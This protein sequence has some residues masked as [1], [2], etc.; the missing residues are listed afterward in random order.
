[1]NPSLSDKRS[2]T[3]YR[4]DIDG[5]RSLAVLAVISFHLRF[6]LSGGFVG[7][8]IFFVI[9]GYL[10]T[11]IIEAGIDAGSFSVLEF[12]ARRAR[13]IL[14]ALLSTVFAS[15]VVASIVL[16][17]PEL[18]AF[19]KSALAAVLFVAN[20][21]FLAVSG[22]FAPAANA[23]PLLHLWSLGIEEQFYI[24]FPVI[25]L[26]LAKYP[27]KFLLLL[28]A[29][30]CIISLAASQ[31]LAGED[32]TSA[33]YLL[34]Y[35]GFELLIGCLTALLTAPRLFKNAA[36]TEATSLA[37]AA[38]LI[39]PAVF[40]GPTTSYPGFGAACPAFGAAMVISAG[41]ARMPL[42]SKWLSA[43]PLVGIGK[44][45][46]SLY[47]VHWPV[48]V[49]GLRIFPNASPIAFAL[50]AVAV[51]FGLALLNY[52][53][54]EQPF[55]QSQRLRSSKRVL[56]TAAAA[57]ACLCG[58]SAWTIHEAGFSPATD[59]RIKRV[60]SYLQYDHDRLY[61]DR[62]CYLSPDQDFSLANMSGCLPQGSGIPAIL[63]GDSH[64]IHLY[65]GLRPYF[66]REGFSLGVL[67]AS[68]C[69]PIIDYHTPVRPKCPSF[70]DG[71]LQAIL[72]LRPR[73][74]VLSARWPTDDASV[75]LLDRTVAALARAGIKVVILGE[76]PLYRIDVPLII[77][78]RL[79]ARDES[80]VANGEFDLEIGFLQWSDR[81]L[82][83]RFSN[84]DDVKFISV[85]QALCPK[86]D[87]PLTDA[88]GAP[89]HF[90]TAH[91]TKEGSLLF[92]E[93]LAP[94][95]LR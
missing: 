6:G 52:R 54:V 85:M 84:R 2:P 91:L 8:D 36:A 3:G 71:A 29:T 78:K 73:I 56:S 31:L 22:Y 37:G 48:I 18:I 30:L 64:A 65:P 44:I 35:R 38:L 24:L 63:W 75:A 28:L 33:F 13:R 46:Y 49:F 26:V 82:S 77:A 47:L 27:R 76:S 86:N 92:A 74:V 5:L 15:S 69:A 12:Y 9:S 81:I 34:P 1:M 43:R 17:P 51:S 62:E 90:D 7:V 16:Y 21:H 59:E 40:F 45:S 42:V 68:A 66:E 11:R 14:P 53:F 32:P 41:E 83:E 79:Q 89:V 80:R 39:L 57:V 4:A 10:I 25:A 70:N 67:T 87:C 58:L 20:I 72:S 19:A 61:R 95:I 88:E 23:V 93:V 50:C 60:L 55:R 94:L